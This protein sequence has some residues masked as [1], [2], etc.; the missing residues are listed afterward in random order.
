[1]KINEAAKTLGVSAET[2][3][4]Y[5]RIGL[6]GRVTRRS[7]GSRDYSDKELEGIRRVTALRKGGVAIE[8]LLQMKNLSTSANRSE[9]EEF[10]EAK[11]RECRDRAD[12]ARQ[13]ARIIREEAQK[14]A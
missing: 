11:I 13:A 5:E 14:W 10:V 4:Y 8:D 2:L 9:A 12:A 3:R 6:I 7:G 1:M